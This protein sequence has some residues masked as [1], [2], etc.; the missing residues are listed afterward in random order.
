MHYFSLIIG[1]INLRIV[2]L[3]SGR[4]HGARYDRGTVHNEDMIPSTNALLSS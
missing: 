1:F 4:H 2:S 3:P